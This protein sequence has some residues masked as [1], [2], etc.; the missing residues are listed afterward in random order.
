MISS[1]IRA[2]A[3]ALALLGVAGV[4]AA[5]DNDPAAPD[6]QFP[7][8]EIIGDSVLTSQESIRIVFRGDSL[9]SAS[10]QDQSNFV[11]INQ[12]TGLR[13]SGAL[14]LARGASGGVSTDT[15]VFTPTETLPFLTLIGVRV[16]NLLTPSGRSLGAPLTFQFQTEPPPVTDLGWQFANSPTNDN[17]TGVNFISR[18]VGYVITNGGSLFR[19]IDGGRTITP[20]F[21]D[22]NTSNT[23]EVRAFGDTVFFVG[24]RKFGVTTRRAL[25]RSTD[26]GLTFDTVRT[27]IPFSYVNSMQRA[28]DGS[29]R[30]V[31]GGLFDK[32]YLYVYDS[33]TN[34][35]TLATGLPPAG[36]VLAGADLSRDVTKAIAA[37]QGAQNGP[38][39]Q[40]GTAI[41]SNDGGLTYQNLSLPLNTFAL[42]GAGFINNN[43]ALLLGDSSV[44]I[45]VNVATGTST[46][47]GVANGIPQ[48][49]RIGPGDFTTFS[50]SKARFAADG[51]TGYITGTFIRRRPGLPDLENGVILQTR[52]GGQ[53]F[54]RLGIA[55]APDDGLG[56]APVRDL[57][58]LATDF[59]VLGGNEGLVATR[60]IAGA[61]T[62][63]V[64]SFTTRP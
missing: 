40:V 21:K 19:T 34:N 53:T 38:N 46:P 29:I 14:R 48:T 4:V 37:F 17:I 50:F 24:A 10:A 31:F 16:Q 6:L 59:A 57:Q 23:F 60:T 12:C 18:S 45:R 56:F 9:S 42:E 27:V 33:R 44:V 5:C 52:D 51:Q 22:I 30:G 63:R 55:G 7:T 3:K 2:G 13:I 32:S 28:P 47:L 35:V 39:S 64:C 25:F 8:A 61:V 15:L 58:V 62:A 43:D 1:S 41:I 54:T 11:V 20:R 26:A 36:T 49:I